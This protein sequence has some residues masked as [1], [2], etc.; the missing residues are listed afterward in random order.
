MIDLLIGQEKE[1]EA[2]LYAERA[3]GRVLLDVL[4]S[5]RK[6]A[7]LPEKEREEARRL[8]QAIV[9]FN[10][11]IRG[12]RLKPAP[13]SAR[14]ARLTSRLES[15]RL[16][17]ESFLNLVY[18]ANPDLKADVTRA[19]SLAI[20][21]LSRLFPD[22]KTALLEY[23]VTKERVYLF[24]L[25][26]P[27]QTTGVSAK[28]HAIQ[29]NQMELAERVRLARQMA[30]EKNPAFTISSRELYKLLIKPAE[31]QLLGKDTICVIPDGPLWEV[32]F[33]ALQNGAG[34]YLIEDLAIHYAQSL[35]V[36]KETGRRDNENAG[37]DSLLAFA[38]PLVGN[39]AVSQFRNTTGGETFNPLPESETE[40]KSLARIFGQDHSR[41]FIG[42]EANE[43]AF[44]SLAASYGI[45]H[46]ATHGMI[47][48]RQPLYSYLLLSRT[49]ADA[50]DD[51]LLEAREVM[52]LNLRA[53]LVVLSACETARGRIGAGEGVVGISWAFFLAGCR[54]TV[55]S[56]WKVSSSVTSELMVGFYRQLK[57]SGGRSKANSL[58]TAALELMKSGRYR[59]P[60]YWAGFIIVGGD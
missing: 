48:D 18:A 45:I 19:P 37:Y 55:V 40:V 2:L 46:F 20:D 1:S 9:A 5:G 26:K 39:E 23:V 50:D 57:K 58:R 51:G 35:G 27:D 44:R 38:N 22:H 24:V 8:N 56:Q 52:N 3:K 32:P 15:A 16:K 7:S 17:Y 10:N 33:Q 12:E 13:D 29:I 31:A 42:A 14:I 49:D 4:G 60:F 6:Q 53:D 25:T 59:H 28:T 34:R 41:V 11:E 47:Y 54:A 21:D 30:A 36:L 43:K